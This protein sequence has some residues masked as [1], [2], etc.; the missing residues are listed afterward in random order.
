MSNYKKGA[1][2]EYRAMRILES[3]GYVCSRA[4]G[5]HGAFDVVG[6]NRSGF[7]LVQVKSNCWPSPAEMELLQSTP[8]PA[9]AQKL[10]YRFNDRQKMPIVKEVA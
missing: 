7:V 1:R 5:S 4:A 6:W 10:V 8:T 3:A 2:N 9:N